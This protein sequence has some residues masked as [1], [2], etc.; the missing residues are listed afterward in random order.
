MYTTL[1][2]PSV[3]DLNLKAK[4]KVNAILLS[5]VHASSIKGEGMEGFA[6]RPRPPDAPDMQHVHMTTKLTEMGIL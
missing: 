4:S 2:R 5:K 6:K 1:I 3:T